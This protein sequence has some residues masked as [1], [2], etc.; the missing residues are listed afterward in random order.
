MSRDQIEGLYR[1]L[2][3][4]KK[5]CGEPTGGLTPDSLAATIDKTAPKVM[6]EKGCRQVDF[7]V[8]IKNDKAVLKA[9]PKK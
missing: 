5:L 8:V 9:I 3:N 1:K 2:M 7:T 4:A 6:Q